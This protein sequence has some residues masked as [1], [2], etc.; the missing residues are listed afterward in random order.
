MFVY[1]TIQRFVET[2]TV[3]DRPRSGRP[4][5]VRTPELVKTVAARIRRNP[6]R[7]QAVLARELSVSKILMTRILR[8]DLGLKAYRRTTGYFLTPQL[9]QMR[10]MKCKCLL[11]RYAGNGHKRIF[12]TD[13]KIF[14]IEQSFNRQND[15]IYATSSRDARERAPKIQRAHHPASVMVWWGVTYDGTI[16]LHFCKKGVKTSAKVYVDTV[17][18]PVVKN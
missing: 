3:E 7:Q 11:Q 5:S 9:K 8:S 1:R 2:G 4:R 17:L 14:N 6:V 18:E 10:M 16:E 12:F 15:K 13:E